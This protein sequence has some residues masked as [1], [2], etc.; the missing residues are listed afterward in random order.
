MQNSVRQTKTCVI[1]AH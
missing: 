1:T